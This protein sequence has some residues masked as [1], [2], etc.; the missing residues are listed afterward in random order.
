MR[1]GNCFL[2]GSATHVVA[3]GNHKVDAKDQ[4]KWVTNAWAEAGK[5]LINHLE[6][7]I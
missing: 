3:Q 7:Q 2:A 5:G 1:S 6:V 4:S